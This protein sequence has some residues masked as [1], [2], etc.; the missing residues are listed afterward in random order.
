MNQLIIYNGEKFDKLANSPKV[1]QV[2]NLKSDI[3]DMMQKAAILNGGTKDPD[4][5]ALNIHVEAI[6]TDLN[7]IHTWLT[8]A[9]LNHLFSEGLRGKYGEYFG[10]NY[11]TVTEWII[12]Y[13]DSS[14]RKAYIEQKTKVKE[15]PVRQMTPEEKEQDDKDYVN[16]FFNLHKKE[17]LKLQAIDVNIYKTLWKNGKVNLDD[18]T[19]EEIRGLARETFFNLKRDGTLDSHHLQNLDEQKAI[20]NLAKRFA[21]RH[22]FNENKEMF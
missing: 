9:E 13:R 20:D 15:L 5:Y 10:I 3:L 21:V 8:Q 6:Y 16:H 17:P 19:K 2:A 14:E 18:E 4:P 7:S 1:T 11:K 22:I 12:A